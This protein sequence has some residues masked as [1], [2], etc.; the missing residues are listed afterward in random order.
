M[1]DSLVNRLLR[2]CPSASLRMIGYEVI[3]HDN[4]VTQQ[5]KQ[6][7]NPKK[8]IRNHFKIAWRNIWKSKLQSMINLLGL[9]TGIVCAVLILLWVKDEVTY[10]KFHSNYDSIY[11]V[12]AHRDY[13][14][15]V[16]TDS[17][18][19]LPLAEAVEKESPQVEKAVVTTHT[20]SRVLSYGD[21]RLSKEGRTVSKHFFDMFSWEFV[22][23]N[24]ETAIA[25][26]SSIVLTQSTAKALFGNE[27]P[28]NKTIRVNN[29]Q[30]VIVSAVIAD[31][32]DNS[33]FQFDFIRPFNYSTPAIKRAM[34]EWISSSWEVFVQIAPG[35]TVSQLNKGIDAIK[36]QHSPNDKISTYFAFP[37][38]KWR[39]YSDFK[40]GQN[41][42]GM[43]AYV[44]LFLIIAVI[45]LLI[46][47]VNFMN[48]STAR[49]EK[50]AR[51]VGIRKTLGAVK[52][53]LVR[54]FFAESF[55]LTFSAFILAIIMVFIL[56]PSFNTLVN[57]DLS[58]SL[59][60]PLF[61]AGALII[62]LFTSAIAGSYPALY[63]S[64]FNP[65]KVL[66]GTF[67]AGKN[68]ILSRRVLIVGQF[69][70]SIFLISATVV[71]Y[72]QIQHVKSRDMGYDANNLI[73]LPSSDDMQKNFDVIKQELL[74]SGMV[75]AMTRTGAAI[76]EIQWR[77][78]SPDWKGK[79]TDGEI[80][81]SGLNVDADFTET[82]GIKLLSGKGFSGMPADSSA[83]LLNKTAV[84]AMGLKNPVGMNMRYGDKNYTVIGVTNNVVMESPHEPVNPNM[85]FCNPDYFDVLTLRLQQGIQPQNALRSIEDIMKKYNPAFPFEYN[86]VDQE[87]GKKFLTVE[88]ISKISKLFAGLAI[89]ICCIGL[90]GLASFT[91]E[92]RTREIGIR[93]ILGASVRQVLVLLSG[94]FLK[95]VIIA[96]AIVTPVA[97][98]LMKNW[99]ERYSY[100][101]E[102][103]AVL[104]VVIGVIILLLTLLVVGLSTVHAAMSNP[105]KSLRTE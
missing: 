26:P 16:F 81:I 53:Q 84:E 24:A 30:D 98:L 51:E 89:F 2:C 1:M 73:M 71:V 100:H 37:M 93:K 76:T 14:N 102:I 43:I 10:N 85:I 56:L 55:L 80:I 29:Q 70:V 58:L 50:R 15:Q 97:W 18:M 67:S 95:L 34:D 94:E 90:V 27:N 46:A 75:S 4:G 47:C 8:M 52:R 91:V 38:H 19:V 103:S 25:D 92:K 49:S 96:F 41:T 66:K 104:F 45:V 32:P 20:Q 99:V 23:G 82:M 6:L 12:I 54:Q 62:I 101:I 87:F 72:Q 64:S 3:K 79:S 57:K 77:S 33:S 68:A 44:R 21:T 48:L 31:T 36:K 7:N 28:L 39:L 105:V 22:L 78:D 88:L 61:W 63:L 74:S 9:T 11:Q 5:Q 42:G 59:G 35:A 65:V 86:F 17:N 40:N 69:M 13:N 83:M 60:D